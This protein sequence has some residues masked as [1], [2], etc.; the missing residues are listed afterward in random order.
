MNGVNVLV[1]YFASL[2]FYA[3][4]RTLGSVSMFPRFIWDIMNTKM[5]LG[6]V[7]LFLFIYF[8]LQFYASFVI[9]VGVYMLVLSAITAGF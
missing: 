9:S 6:V 3:S 8:S 2:Q 5:E 7:F 1:L 4:Y